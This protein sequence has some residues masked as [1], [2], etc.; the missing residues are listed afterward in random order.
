MHPEKLMEKQKLLAYFAS[1]FALCS[2]FSNAEILGFPTPLSV[3]LCAV[4]PPYFSVLMLPSTVISSL[5]S[6]NF[7]KRFYLLLAL[8][9]CALLRVIML[10]LKRYNANMSAICALGGYIAGGFVLIFVPIEGY[11]FF[12]HI[13]AC[14]ICSVGAYFAKSAYNSFKGKHYF[15]LSTPDAIYICGTFVL[16]VS[17]LSSINAASVN[18]GIITSMV[19][20]LYIGKILGKSEGCVCA[21]LGCLGVSLCSPSAARLCVLMPVFVLI[22][23][24]FS[25]K[26]KKY[27]AAVF[28]LE[29]LL[30]GIIVSF[31]A[32]SLIYL[33]NVIAAALFFT[34]YNNERMVSLLSSTPLKIQRRRLL[35]EKR[36]HFAA[37][38]IKELRKDT[39][40]VSQILRRRDCLPSTPN[41]L[42]SK[43]CKGCENRRLCWEEK[44]NEA[45]EAFGFF[46]P[47]T[48]VSPST[49]PA[50]FNDCPNRLE[51]AREYSVFEQER[52]LDKAN[53]NLRLEIQSAIFSLLEAQEE[54]F[55]QSTKYICKTDDSD[56]D[57][58]SV[59]QS[60][61]H[62]IGLKN[63]YAAV[64]RESGDLIKAEIY[65]NGIELAEQNE[66]VSALSKALDTELSVSGIH[67]TSD[68]TKINLV[69]KADSGFD[70]AFSQSS[71]END[72]CGDYCM[73]YSDGFGNEYAALS[74]GMGHGKDAALNAH[75]C[76]SLLKKLTC[77]G[78]P[79]YAAA[80]LI[81]S[82]MMIKDTSDS[83]AT[84][85]ITKIDAQSRNTEILKSG[86][87]ATLIR[88]S[89]RVICIKAASFPLGIV[90][91]AEPYKK[92]ISLKSGDSFVMISDGI[93]EEYYQ[94]IKSLL[95]HKQNLSAKELA[96]EI[97]GTVSSS[98]K[99]GKKDDITVCVGI[100]K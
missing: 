97:C 45:Y 70:F 94:Y 21:A 53:D 14:S 62:D 61:L 93:E 30:L 57:L 12:D 11:G 81:N 49:L 18:L 66:I 37:S 86:A 4:S 52:A 87:S 90:G 34:M 5:I 91:T 13:I 68:C 16:V 26:G 1:A 59:A 47:H 77:S 46:R 8:A 64:F 92:S 42:A 19:S 99:T 79:P 51:I 32:D 31:S 22:A 69:Q 43:F 36:M 55:I 63:S 40:Y 15:S 80:G 71:A 56:Y 58:S 72:I 85:D 17:I 7:T 9:V 95:L 78:I 38:S 65:V 41:H 35:L 50:Y 44:E 96:D 76:L 29:N 6:G 54:T 48:A 82:A 60:A 23:S 25:K 73:L 84:L 10:S 100:I 75:F 74:D 27:A 2:L 33:V 98:Y 83:F 28:V 39:L 67:R 89:G 3:S 24:V 20:S 88:T